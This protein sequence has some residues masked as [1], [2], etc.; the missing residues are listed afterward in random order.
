MR[1]FYPHPGTD[2]TGF[3]FRRR[4]GP[5]DEGDEV[6]NAKMVNDPE[7]GSVIEARFSSVSDPEALA[8][9][10][11]G[12]TRFDRSGQYVEL[13]FS[14]PR[15]IR[16]GAFEDGFSISCEEGG[17]GVG[18]MTG[19]ALVWLGLQLLRRPEDAA[20]FLASSGWP[21]DD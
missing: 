17:D 7:G 15:F 2:G 8:S 5:A 19:E 20:A 1:T 11:E 9:Y 16:L 14:A 13:R 21:D 3:C 6:W 18:H 10:T 12:E 4:L